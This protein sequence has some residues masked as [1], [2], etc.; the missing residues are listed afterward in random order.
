MKRIILV[1]VFAISVGFSAFGQFDINR[2]AGGINVGY[3]VP[4]G[5][6]KEYAKGGLTYNAVAL[7]KLTDRVGVGV[8]YSS[9]LTAAFDSNLSGV[10]GLNLYGLNSFLLKGVYKFT[11]GTLRPYVGAGVGVASVAEPD[12]SSNG[13]TTEGA[14]R[15]G[16]G[17][18][19]EL[20]VAIKNFVISYSYQLNGKSPKEPVFNSK[21]ADLP[22]NYHKIAIGYIYNF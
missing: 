7:Y 15:F 1:F 14:K 17:A 2:L 5:D 21:V 20:G 4:L 12:V 13:N 9:A 10:L 3:A 19:A 22:V 18:N 11:D 8:E 16:L 6:F